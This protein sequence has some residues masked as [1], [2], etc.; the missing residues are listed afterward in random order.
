MPTFITGG[1]VLAP[2]GRIA[3]GTVVIGDS[4]ILEVSD[5]RAALPDR[6]DENRCVRTVRFTWVYRYSH[7]RV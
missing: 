6:R 7:A 5:R 2:S 4:R 3:G 1:V